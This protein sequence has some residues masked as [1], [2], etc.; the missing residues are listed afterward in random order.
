M[1]IVYHHFNNNYKE[2]LIRHN[3]KHNKN[4]LKEKKDYILKIISHNNPNGIK[5]KKSPIDQVDQ[6]LN[7]PTHILYQTAN[8]IYTIIKLKNLINNFMLN[9]NKLKKWYKNNLKLILS[10]LNSKN[11]ITKYKKKI[12]NL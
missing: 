2:S 12:L 11:Y 3:L 9:Y 10:N 8:I 6:V 4:T 1:G 7:L 5:N